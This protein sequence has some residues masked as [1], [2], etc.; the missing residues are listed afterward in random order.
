MRYTLG[1][2]LSGSHHALTSTRLVLAAAVVVSHTW[3]IGGFGADP[4]LGDLTLGTFAL[5]GFFAI[6]GYLLAGS[7][8]R[9]PLTAFLLRR[10]ARIYPGLW[11]ALLVTAFVAAPIG[12]L[13]GAGPFDPLSAAR[14]VLHNGVGVLTQPGIGTQLAAA[15]AAGKWNIPLWT[16]GFE[17]LCYLAI[18]LIFAVPLLRRH[19][20]V[21]SS[22][23]VVATTAT[24]LVLVR[25]TPHPALDSLSTLVT[26]FGFFAAG[27]LVW[28]VRDRLRPGPWLL[29]GLAVVTGVAA[30]AGKTFV[31][32]P[33]PL[34][35]LVIMTAALSPVGRGVTA[36][37]S[38]GVYI[39]GWPI[40]Q[41][42]VLWGV[43]TQGP[44]VFTTAAVSGALALAYLSWT[45]VE[46]PAIDW[47]RGR[48]RP[49]GT[50]PSGVV[51]V[52]APSITSPA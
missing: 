10:G 2:S 24:H 25:A 5:L 28:S 48:T 16:L 8:S 35:L 22:M 33:L 19:P 29:V 6:S 43:H 36:D 39:Y 26:L 17:L 49:A 37:L 44:W 13:A 27:M 23:A 4:H 12:A 32:S 41:L 3:P 40:Q 45:A 47:V 11:V 9:L 51:A 18:A 31:L 38:F 52:S 34:A 15:P 42:L 7:R 21:T 50:G 30:L 46:R 14:F 20:A 1:E